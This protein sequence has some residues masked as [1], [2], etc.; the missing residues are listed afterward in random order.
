[1]KV[2]AVVG[3]IQIALCVVLMVFAYLFSPAAEPLSLAILY[4]YYP[5]VHVLSEA[6][7][8]GEANLFMPALLGVPLGILLYSVICGLIF[9]YIKQRHPR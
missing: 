4:A 2:A 8:T 7:F 3:G 9:K 5:T 1:M 6:G